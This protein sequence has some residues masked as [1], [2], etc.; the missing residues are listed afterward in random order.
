MKMCQA[1][2]RNG[3]DVVLIAR[4]RHDN[5][6]SGVDDIFAFYGVEKCFEFVT[7]PWLHIKG[8][9]YIYGLFAAI[10]AKTFNPDLVYCRNIVGCFF[11][12]LFGLPVILESH[13]PIENS[14]SISHW[15]FRWLI[16][17][18][19]LRN[20]VVITHRLKEYYQNH[21]THIRGK[22]HVAPDGA[23]PVPENLCPVDLPNKGKRIQV[24]YVGH[25]YKGRGADIIIDIAKACDWADFHLVGGEEEDVF[26]WKTE[27]AE[28]KNI[29]FHGFV[30]PH[31][32]EKLRISFDILLAPYQ[33][34]VS[35]A[36][37]K[38]GGGGNSVEW[39]SPIKIFEYMA[40]SKPIICSD[41]PVLREIL[42]HEFNAL[43]CPPDD[44]NIWVNNL[45]R[46][47]DEPELRLRL[48]DEAKKQ[49]LVNFTWKTR[50]KQLLGKEHK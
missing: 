48:G 10:K 31:D 42:K 8:R 27:V 37:T 4:D 1:F 44:L 50:A 9:S 30:S 14:F 15:M 2:T 20:F 35:V 36:C 34:E 18:P 12:A 39:M 3:H 25:L 16:S 6:E 19:R 21:Y 17:S 41:L 46:L 49:F 45:K 7:L 32:A 26:Y 29:I 47:R 23:D 5:I 24:G 33:Y 43:L 40:A 38:A 13:G 22:I 28:Q 11:A